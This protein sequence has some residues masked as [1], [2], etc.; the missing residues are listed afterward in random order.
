MFYSSPRSSSRRAFTLIELLV[1]SAILAV[2]IGLLL[3]AVQKVRV[4]ANRMSCSNN[5]KQL[6]PSY[7][8][9]HDLFPFEMLR[10]PGW[11]WGAFLLPCIEQQ[12]LYQRL[13]PV[14]TAALPVR[15]ASWAAAPEQRP[16][17]IVILADDLGY[18]D[19]GVQG[20][21]DIPTP[22]L[23]SIAKAGMR[24]TNAYSSCPYCSPS[25]A[26]LMTGRY[27]TRF[28][29]E[30]NNANED[31]EG[32]PIPA[33][34]LQL[35]KTRFGH[36]FHAY[37]GKP[38]AQL[39]LP[40]S[41]Q[42]FAQRMKQL[43]YATAVVAK[44]HLGMAAPFRPRAR[45]FDEFY[46]TLP[47]MG[48]HFSPRHFIDSRVA[49]EPVQMKDPGFY[50]TDAYSARAVDLIQRWKDRPFFIYLA[51][52]APHT[53]KEAP[54]KYLARFTT[55]ADQERRVYAAMVAAMDD[56]VGAVLAKLR[57]LT[58]EENTLIVFL[59]DNGG[60]MTKMAENGARNGKLKGQKG[61]TWEG[62]IRVPMFIQWKH[63]LSEGV[64]YDQPVIAL[65]LLPT[66]VAAAGEEAKPEWKLDGVNLLPYLL[67]KRTGR[68]HETLYWRFGPQWAIRQGDWKLVVGYDYAAKQA[69]Y[70][71]LSLMVE[72]APKLFNLAEDPG[73]KNDLSS[74]QPKMAQ[75]LLAAW[76]VW[77][78][79]QADPAWPPIP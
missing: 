8:N 67:G 33:E 51:F 62:G 69:S 24:F 61:D 72:P 75:A 29:Y 70:Q 17:I 10:N 6:A 38:G 35:W 79:T 73:E 36:E 78:A 77:N 44:W 16:N 1:V 43:G 59:S 60:P 13:N 28:G 32:K 4:A 23:D 41:E 34:V 76:K 21:N 42:T 50:T 14:T 68:P 25:R 12:N 49:H 3:P 66:A 30:F 19:L 71:P 57:E 58:L 48:S 53:P 55:I 20:G 31:R 15:T 27:P 45:G 46:G 39:G 40:L 64:V 52:T 2:L 26:G 63:R 54:E 22:H 18:A 37:Q 74:H 47:A 5:L 11:G 9:T 7:H 56:A 65:D